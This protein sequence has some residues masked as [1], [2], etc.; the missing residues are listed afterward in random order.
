MARAGGRDMVEVLKKYRV[1]MP[2]IEDQIYEAHY[3][4]LRD[5]VLPLWRTRAG[6]NGDC[7]VFAA[8]KDWM[9]EEVE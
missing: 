9:V 1:Y 6:M 4:D 8:P 3:V 2:H 5:G 7:L